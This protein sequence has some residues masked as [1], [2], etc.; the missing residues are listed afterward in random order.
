MALLDLGFTDQELVE[1]VRRELSYRE[2][3]YPRLIADN[4]MSRQK[5]EQQIELMKAVLR[6]I[7]TT[8]PPAAPPVMTIAQALGAFV[9]QLT[10]NLHPT[11]QRAVVETLRRLADEL[12]RRPDLHASTAAAPPSS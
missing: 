8:S 12:T 6:R 4:K 2:T 10:G 11:Q 7:E 3:V 9:E 1:C 5:A